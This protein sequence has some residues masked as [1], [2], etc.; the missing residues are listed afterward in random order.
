[1]DVTAFFPCQGLIKG[2][3]KVEPKECFILY[4]DPLGKNHRQYF[5][6]NIEHMTAVPLRCEDV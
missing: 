3:L 5:R 6:I 4:A 1:M 2:L